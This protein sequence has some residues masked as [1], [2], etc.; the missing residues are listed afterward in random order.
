MNVLEPCGNELAIELST[1]T[2]L[3][4]CHLQQGSVQVDVGDEVKMGQPIAKCGNS[5]HTSEPHLHIHHQRQ[6]PRIYPFGFA[7]GLR[8][9]FHSLDGNAFPKGG[10]DM[11]GDTPIAIGDVIAFTP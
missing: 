4:L 8:L 1:G 3:M 5:G 10:I 9:G 11:D 2:F 7:E 6:D